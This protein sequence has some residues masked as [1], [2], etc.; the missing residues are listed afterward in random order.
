MAKV[1]VG[2]EQLDAMVSCHYL[3]EQH[4]FKIW[5]CN[6]AFPKCF[7]ELSKFSDKK[8]LSLQ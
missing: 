3:H 6:G 4:S 8:Y 1:S 7:T 5:G 2:S